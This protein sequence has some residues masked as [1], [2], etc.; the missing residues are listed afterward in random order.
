M[1]S[2]SQIDLQ[3]RVDNMLQQDFLQ[4]VMSGGFHPSVLPASSSS[5]SLKS[6]DSTDYSPLLPTAP[7]SFNIQEP[8]MA[9]SSPLEEA[10]RA[11]TS[12]QPIVSSPHHQAINQIRDIRL[13]ARET[14]EAAITSAILA[15][16]SSSS[17]QTSQCLPQ[18]NLT[19]P[20]PSAF[21][22]YRHSLGPKTAKTRKQTLFNRSIYYLNVMANVRKQEL[23]MQGAGNLRPMTAQSW[24]HMMKERTRR[25]KITDMLQ[26]LRSELP[27]GS[28]VTTYAQTLTTQNPFF[29]I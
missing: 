28:K 9:E 11:A 2:I 24:Q 13:P 7:P 14:E 8:L 19:R 29:P 18:I 23:Q 26:I 21:R 27:P 17:P 4:R 16:L 25:R 22:Q 20:N 12:F 10:F 15:V 6:F 3:K 5:S 1:Q